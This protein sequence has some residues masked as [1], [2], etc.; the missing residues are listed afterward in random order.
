MFH[1]R[2][3]RGGAVDGVAVMVQR[4][5]VVGDDDS[6]PAVQDAPDDRPLPRCRLVGTVEIRIAKVRGLRLRLEHGLFRADDAVA[7]LV[8]RGIIDERA[9][10]GDRDRQS[11]RLVQPGVRPPA[12][13]GHTAHGYEV[14]TPTHRRRR[15]HSEP[16]IHRNDDVPRRFGQRVSKRHLVV[17]VG[18]DVHKVGRRLPSLVLAPVQDRDVVP[19]LDQPLHDRKAARARAADHEDAHDATQPITRGELPPRTRRAS[20]SKLTAARSRPREVRASGASNARDQTASSA[21]CGPSRCDTR[22][23]R[24]SRPTP[25]AGCL[26]R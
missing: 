14:I 10:L 26:R 11:G 19:V 25:S 20:T 9:V 21:R 16:S 4:Q 12:V 15:D 7:L 18:V 1:R 6:L 22:C 8:E 24:R 3:D 23:S 2:N 17:R 13:R 5:A